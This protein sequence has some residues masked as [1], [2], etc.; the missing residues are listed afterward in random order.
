MALQSSHVAVFAETGDDEL[1][2]PLPL[3][4]QERA[5]SPSCE[6][7]LQYQQVAPLSPPRFHRRC[8]LQPP[9]APRCPHNPGRSY[10]GFPAEH[11]SASI[12]N[13]I[14]RHG[15]SLQR[16]RFTLAIEGQC[17]F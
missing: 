13:R 4:A 16:V 3:S 17:V 7:A 1:L 6:G 14:G 11:C 12:A 5:L 8:V 2:A 10:L 15:M 9:Y